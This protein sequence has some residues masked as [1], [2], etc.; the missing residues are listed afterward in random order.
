VALSGPR[1]SGRR[2]KL[3][4]RNRRDGERVND[5]ETRIAGKIGGV[6][7]N[8]GVDAVSFH[9]CHK[10]GVVGVFPFDF[11]LADKLFPR[12]E[13]AVAIRKK[14]EQGLGLLMFFD[15]DGYLQAKSIFFD[16]PG[17]NDPKFVEHLRNKKKLIASLAQRL[18]GGE[19]GSVVGVSGL[20]YAGEDVGVEKDPHSPRPA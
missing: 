15:D 6:K 14:S 19:G 12:G 2:R 1:G 18:D 20:G 11:E 9:R 10:A 8:G 7:G 4:T 13:D 17:A 16:G 3:L 5:G